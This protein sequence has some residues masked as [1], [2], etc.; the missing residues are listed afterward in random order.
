[1]RL[2]RVTATASTGFSGTGF[3]DTLVIPGNNSDCVIA[4]SGGAGNTVDLRVRTRR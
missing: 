1:M 3:G 2:E 4:A